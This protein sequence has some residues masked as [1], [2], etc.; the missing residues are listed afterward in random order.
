MLQAFNHRD[1]EAIVAACD[2]TVD[3]RSSPY[4]ELSPSTWSMPLALPRGVAQWR[5]VACAPTQRACAAWLVVG[6]HAQLGPP[7]L[8]L[9]NRRLPFP[10]G[11][12]EQVPIA[13]RP[14]KLSAL[15]IAHLAERRIPDDLLNSAAELRIAMSLSTLSLLYVPPCDSEAGSVVSPAAAD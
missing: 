2:P 10:R 4:L 9:E 6:D 15:E 13:Q 11:I 12:L 5:V 14:A 1:L 3:G 8:G 7:V